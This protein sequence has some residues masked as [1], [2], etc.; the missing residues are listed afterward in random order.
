[1]QTSM[2]CVLVILLL[3]NQSCGGVD[4][5]L[6][7]SNPP[8]YDPKK[9]YSTAA[10][11]TP[12]LAQSAMSPDKP[13]SVS[14]AAPDS[15]E[16][17]PKKPPKPGEPPTGCSEVSGREDKPIAGEGGTGGGSGGGS[18][19]GGGGGERPARP[20]GEHPS[21]VLEFRSMIVSSDPDGDPGQ[22][23]ASAVIP[24][25]ASGEVSPRGEMKYVGQGMITYQ[26][27]PLPNWEPCTALVRGQG[28]LPM[29]VFQAFIHVERPPSRSNVSH[30]GSAMIEL[31][32][33]IVGGSQETTTGGIPAYI[34]YQCV[35]NKP[36][37]YSFW[38]SHYISGRA[39]VSGDPMEMFLVKNWTYVGQNGVVATKTLRSTCGG[40]CDQ[41]VATFT[42][43]EGDDSGASTPR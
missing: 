38:S 15:C 39:E 20:T 41:E 10:E 7:S 8:E 21:Y 9:V 4:R 14:K 23:Q 27:G 34:N 2:L 43:R 12:S 5:H 26:T 3:L 18:S 35:P 30:G 40:M 13:A 36:K 11:P 42:L 6:P 29:R 32:Y 33:G 16:K 24:L 22:S 31:L 28:R 17:K 37:P 1:M 25:V 19:G